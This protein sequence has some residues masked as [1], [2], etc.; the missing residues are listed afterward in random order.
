MNIILPS[1]FKELLFAGIGSRETPIF[2]MNI[3]ASLTYILTVHGEYSLRSGSARGADSYFEKGLLSPSQKSEIFLPKAGFGGRRN[4]NANYIIETNTISRMDSMDIID[5]YKLHEKWEFLL[6]SKGDSFS[7]N[8]H[9]RN[10][11]QILGDLSD[12][13]R[14]VKFVCCWTPDGANELSQI[15]ES[16]GGT[17][18][19]IRLALHLDIPVFNLARLEDATRILKYLM[20]YNDLP[21]QLPTLEEL[22]THCHIL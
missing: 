16:T 14:P 5:T 18:T 17:R 12:G 9:I 7:V 2:F 13:F 6:R 8:A 10:V 11:F 19:A 21:F 20:K 4:T 15:T 3:M 1:D 22:Q